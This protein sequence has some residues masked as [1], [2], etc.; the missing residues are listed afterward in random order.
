MPGGEVTGAH[1]A[2]GAQ[3]GGDVHPEEHRQPEGETRTADGEPEEGARAGAGRGAAYAEPGA[4][5]ET[6][7][8][9]AEELR[10]LA[11]WLGL[12]DVVVGDRGD[13]APLLHF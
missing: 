1:G 11:T 7:E 4:P 5:D 10:E 8:E 13:L 3:A 6:A 2:P 9:L 12:A